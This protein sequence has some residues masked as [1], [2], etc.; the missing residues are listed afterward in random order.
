M[1]GAWGKSLTRA[2]IMLPRW[3]DNFYILSM[4]I[5]FTLKELVFTPQS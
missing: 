4:A 2:P 3:L 1:L 5:L